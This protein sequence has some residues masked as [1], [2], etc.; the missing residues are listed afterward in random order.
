MS[1][2]FVNRPSD[3]DSM[4]KTIVSQSFPGATPSTLVLAATEN[5]MRSGFVEL[6]TTR[7]G[8]KRERF[9]WGISR[10]GSSRLVG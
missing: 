3:F 5:E 1:K 8:T 4:V 6:T 9:V 7:P 2:F 10:M